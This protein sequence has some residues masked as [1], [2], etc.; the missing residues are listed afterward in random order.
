VFRD[1]KGPNVMEKDGQIVIIDIG[2][3]N[4]KGDPELSL[5]G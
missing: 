4:I 3:S 1:L 5:I 2:Y